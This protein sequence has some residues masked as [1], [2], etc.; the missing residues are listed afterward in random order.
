MVYSKHAKVFL[1]EL[2]RM[3]GGFE[4]ALE[5]MFVDLSADQPTSITAR[6]LMAVD[7]A[8]LASF[9]HLKVKLTREQY[10]FL[11]DIYN[12]FSGEKT[13]IVGN[14]IRMFSK[15]AE[16]SSIQEPPSTILT[17]IRKYDIQQD[18]DLARICKDCFFQILSVTL[19]SVESPTDEISAIVS[20]VDDFWTEVLTLS[21]AERNCYRKESMEFVCKL[22]A[23]VTQLIPPLSLVVRQSE[24]LSNTVHDIEGAIRSM[25]CQYAE[26]CLLFDSPF[27]Q[28]KLEVLSDLC[29][30]F[31]VFGESS[32][33]TEVRKKLIGAKPR[34]NA[35]V[36]PA[37]ICLLDQYDTAMDTHFC[38]QSRE[39]VLQ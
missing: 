26:E 6:Y 2:E 1:P 27:A 19:C 37:L 15:V 39:L 22:N 29:P 36:L 25:F 13:A 3:F 8:K 34:F 38:L 9:L 28:A 21:R 30:A 20:E 23:A 24:Y 4:V 18:T 32:T 5:S 35:T 31:M 33:V 7:V 12:F 14:H 10:G 11:G 17:L 16:L